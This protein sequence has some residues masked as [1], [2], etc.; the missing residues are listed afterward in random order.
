MVMLLLFL[1]VVVLAIVVAFIIT[2]KLFPRSALMLLLNRFV[3]LQNTTGTSPTRRNGQFAHRRLDDLLS[4]GVVISTRRAPTTVGGYEVRNR[5]YLRMNDELDPEM[6]WELN[7]G[8]GAPAPPDPLHPSAGSDADGAPAVFGDKQNGKADGTAAPAAIAPSS[9]AS[10]ALNTISPKRQPV[11]ILF[12]LHL[13]CN[14]STITCTRKLQCIRSRT[15]L[16]FDW[17]LL[18]TLYVGVS[19]ECCI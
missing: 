16:S 14:K 9:D 8:V 18:Y 3:Y 6:D 13:T 1:S 4:G 17:L 15:C 7:E 19:A 12:E 11:Q 10:R 5:M 2:K